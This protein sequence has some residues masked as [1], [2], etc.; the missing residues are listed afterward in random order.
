[1]ERVSKEKS[2]C[3]DFSA[4][5][6]FLHRNSRSIKSGIMSELHEAASS[7]KASFSE[8]LNLY[9]LLSL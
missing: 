6:I 9:V 3:L 7:V 4:F 1:M 2:R 8:M 5:G